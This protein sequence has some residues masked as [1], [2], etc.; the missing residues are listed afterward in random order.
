MLGKRLLIPL[1]VVLCLMLAAAG[2]AYAELKAASVF[3]GWDEKSIQ[4]A[5]S[6]NEVTF[7]GHWVPFLHE[8]GF[9]KKT[10]VATNPAY[11]AYACP[12]SP[13]LTTK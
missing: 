3:Y 10:Y 8:L 2:I 13:T 4:Y 11:P 9:D 6:M 7:D 12:A 5:H 1:L